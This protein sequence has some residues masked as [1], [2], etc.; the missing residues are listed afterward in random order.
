ME[1]TGTCDL[2][3]DGLV[4]AWAV[5]EEGWEIFRGDE[6]CENLKVY[7]RRES[8]VFGLPKRVRSVDF[9]EGG[10]WELTSDWR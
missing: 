3:K 5:L 9:G 4:R 6:C 1:W 2:G 7:F 10:S 8:D